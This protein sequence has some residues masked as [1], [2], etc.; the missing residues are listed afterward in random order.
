MG[1]EEHPQ[2]DLDE[3]EIAPLLDKKQIRGAFSSEDDPQFAGLVSWFKTWAVITQRERKSKTYLATINGNLVGYITIASLV[4][5]LDLPDIPNDSVLEAN[6]VLLGKLY[7]D[8]AY[9]SFGIGTR[10]LD[11]V[12]DIGLNLDEII[13]CQAIV[14]DSNPNPRTVAFYERYGFERIGINDDEIRMV[15]IL[16]KD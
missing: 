5:R 11:F 4:V 6:N 16:P 1:K 12:V 9:R 10:L 7:I 3:L 13:G 2:I 14:V 15:F 8:K